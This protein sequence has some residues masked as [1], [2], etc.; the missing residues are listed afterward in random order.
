MRREYKLCIFQKFPDLGHDPQMPQLV[1]TTEEFGV[2][3]KS[4]FQKY[5]GKNADGSIPHHVRFIFAPEKNITVWEKHM[6]EQV[7]LDAALR[8]DFDV[9]TSLIKNGIDRHYKR[10]IL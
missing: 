4:I 6:C 8:L 10:A 1:I 2:T 5:P 3:V 7:E 9:Y